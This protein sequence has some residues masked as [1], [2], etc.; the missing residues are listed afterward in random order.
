MWRKMLNPNTRS[1]QAVLGVAVVVLALSLGSQLWA[2][3]RQSPSRAQMAPAGPGLA[4]PTPAA[5]AQAPAD[6]AAGEHEAAAGPQVSPGTDS[7]PPAEAVPTTT[8]VAPAAEST[9][10]RVG[11]QAG[12]WLSAELPDELA[13][14]RTST[15]TAGGG[16]PEWQLNLDIARRVAALL[17][18]EGIAVN[19]LPATVPPGYEADAFVAL[20]AD[21]DS[22]GQMSGFKLARGR[23]RTTAD[24]ADALIADITAEYQAATKLGIDS[25]ISRNMTGYYAFSGRRIQHAVASD[26][27]A[28]ILEM[29]FMTNASDLNI[30]LHKPDTV[31]QGIASGILRFLNDSA[32][33]AN[34]P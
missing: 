11:L 29:G 15:G 24:A 17:T 8:P 23:S 31:A 19:V 6:A 9:V 26:T 1:G 27:P 7:T 4:T 33:N 10:K 20:H 5:T 30:L 34:T 32:A 2:G 28:V 22:T 3:G 25:H 18:A 12:H 14:L 21:G 16:V 13:R